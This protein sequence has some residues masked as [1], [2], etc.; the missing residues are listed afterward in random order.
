[1]GG[2]GAVVAADTCGRA[3]SSLERTAVRIPTLYRS[4]CPCS[5][6]RGTHLRIP[7]QERSYRLEYGN[8]RCRM[9]GAFHL[10]GTLRSTDVPVLASR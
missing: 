10:Y 1:M 8:V 3:N 9:E 6:V 5:Q 4:R 2:P 7:I